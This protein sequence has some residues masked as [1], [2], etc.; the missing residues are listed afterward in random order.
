LRGSADVIKL[1][2]ELNPNIQVMARTGY[3]KELHQLRAEGTEMV[4]SGEGEV[5][6]ALAGAV[7][8]CLGATPEQIERERDRVREELQTGKAIQA[9]H[10]LPLRQTGEVPILRDEDIQRPASQLS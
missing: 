4:F 5:A 10:E 3:V 7:L 2:K 9:E 1:A 6:L 8:E